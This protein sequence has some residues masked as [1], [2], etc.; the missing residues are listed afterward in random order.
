LAVIGAAVRGTLSTRYLHRYQACTEGYFIDLT[1]FTDIKPDMKIVKEEIFG[2]VGIVI[3]FTNEE[4][5]F[6]R[7]PYLCLPRNSHSSFM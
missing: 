4:G 2:P 7:S 1:I 6:F 3:K 5:A